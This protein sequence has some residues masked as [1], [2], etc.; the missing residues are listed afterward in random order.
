M[1][2]DILYYER[3]CILWLSGLVIA[4]IGA[5]LPLGLP[6][7]IATAVVIAGT[8]LQ[9]PWLGLCAWKAFSAYREL[10]KQL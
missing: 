6:V 7:P 1:R 4:W 8:I 2:A 3:L 9:L 10:R 5:L